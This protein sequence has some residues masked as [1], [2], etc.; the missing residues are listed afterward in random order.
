MDY[1]HIVRQP[2]FNRQRQLH[3]YEL[4]LRRA[5]LPDMDEPPPDITEEAMLRPKG[6]HKLATT[7][8]MTAGLPAMI[9]FDTAEL[10]EMAPLSIPKKQLIVRVAS[11]VRPT[12]DVINALI[13]ICNRGYQ[14]AVHLP[15]DPTWEP[16]YPLLSYVLVNLKTDSQEAIVALKAQLD[17]SGVNYQS[18]AIGVDSY[19]HF[20][21]AKKLGFSLF[22]GT[23]FSRPQGHNPIDLTPQ[24]EKLVQL[25]CECSKPAADL[26]LMSSII[27]T[28]RAITERLIKYVN[29]PAFLRGNPIENLT[30]AL[31]YLGEDEVK[32]FATVIA[33]GQLNDS[34]PA[35]LLRLAITRARFCELLAKEQNN[36]VD[37]ARA[38]LVGLFSTLD[39]VMDAQ[40]TELLQRLSLNTDVRQALIDHKGMM[41]GYL[42]V[43]STMEKGSWA[44][45]K[46][47]LDRL[48]VPEESLVRMYKDAIQWANA[49]ERDK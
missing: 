20:V 32:R 27:E 3:S 40:L 38:F 8:D 48:K 4:L 2:I 47:A 42:A 9:Q 33:V 39:A 10:L 36:T 18:M 11:S 14:L 7:L 44:R 26:L 31:V 21:Q 17:E 6:P 37:P 49:Y 28:D 16:I 43:V 5:P 41:A 25:I 15:N 1:H 34:K 45:L 35:E 13:K 46:T 12:S 29:S 19:K 23:F 24:Q 22:Q 30:Q